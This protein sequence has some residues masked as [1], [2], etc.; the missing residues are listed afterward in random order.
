MKNLIITLALA[1]SPTLALA[2]SMISCPDVTNPD[3]T[4]LLFVNNS[5]IAQLR[6]QKQGS[7]PKAFAV[8][9]VRVEDTISIYTVSG[10]AGFLTVDNSALENNGGAL[11]FAG[12]RFVCES[13]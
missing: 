10:V 12:K 3:T 13:N 6:I 7:L 11:S 8:Q 4:V 5:K 2:S 9:E 1:L